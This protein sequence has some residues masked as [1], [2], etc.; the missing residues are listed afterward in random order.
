MRMDA[1][2]VNQS[3]HAT[4]EGVMWFVRGKC[5]QCGK[6][7]PPVFT[8]LSQS[9]MDTFSR[10][11]EMLQTTDWWVDIYNVFIGKSPGIKVIC[12]CPICDKAVQGYRTKGKEDVTTIVTAMDEPQTETLKGLA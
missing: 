11:R 3:E 7:T 10:L 8:D 4:A 5:T 12:R 9:P 1:R 6:L 2:A